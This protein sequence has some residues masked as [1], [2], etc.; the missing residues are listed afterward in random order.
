M[1]EDTNPLHETQERDL[2]TG[3]ELH[4]PRESRDKSLHLGAR[5]GYRRAPSDYE[6]DSA[7]TERQVKALFMERMSKA[8]DHC[9]QLI[10]LSTLVIIA[11]IS[12]LAYMIHNHEFAPTNEN[13]T[14]GPSAYVLVDYGA[15]QGGL[16]LYKGEWWRLLTPVFLHAGIL[17]LA[18]NIFLQWQLGG[19]LNILFGTVPWS[20]IYFLSGIYGNILRYTYTR[21]RMHHSFC[22]AFSHCACAFF[23]SCIFDPDTVGVGSSGALMGVLSSFAVFMVFTWNKYPDDWRTA[24]N[25]NLFSVLVAMTVTMCLSMV[26]F[27]DGAA[28][29]GGMLMGAVLAICFLSGEMEGTCCKVRQ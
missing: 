16:I 20:L 21:S 23:L 6:E 2:E 11:Q 22:I 26:E 3:L 5:R 17:H 13:P 4:P 15:K 8:S 1:S 9:S 12:L 29:G 7:Q 14:Y 10:T 27:I 19:F 28:H 18:M 25:C 24:R